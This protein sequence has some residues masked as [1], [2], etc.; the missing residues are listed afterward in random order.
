MLYGA[1]SAGAVRLYR[2]R[3]TDIHHILSG[4]KI[5]ATYQFSKSFHYTQMED[6]LTP[7]LSCHLVIQ[8]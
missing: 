6:Q 1:A 4:A 7:P 5:L 8:I 3:G 2:S